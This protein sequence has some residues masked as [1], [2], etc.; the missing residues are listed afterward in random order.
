MKCV[1]G[2]YFTNPLML[3]V[4]FL[5]KSYMFYM[6]QKIITATY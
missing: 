5:I 3:N 4:Y 6:H 2:I 1:A